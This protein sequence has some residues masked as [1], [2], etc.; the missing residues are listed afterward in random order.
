MEDITTKKEQN[1]ERD[2]SFYLHLHSSYSVLSCSLVIRLL[3]VVFSCHENFV[4]DS[5][6]SLED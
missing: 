2:E 1:R 3:F 5:T 6:F 4:L